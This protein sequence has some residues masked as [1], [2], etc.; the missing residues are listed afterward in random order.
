MDNIGIYEDRKS[1]MRG[2][3]SGGSKDRD[4]HLYCCV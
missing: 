3:F 1:Y 4:L 2:Q